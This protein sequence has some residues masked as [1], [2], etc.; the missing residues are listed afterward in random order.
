[1]FV[2]FV[3]SMIYSFLRDFVCE[4]TVHR[5]ENRVQLP[6]YISV[7]SLINCHSLGYPNGDL[8]KLNKQSHVDFE[9]PGR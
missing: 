7:T 4:R 5:K 8:M 9:L 2:K 1:V 6:C 3:T